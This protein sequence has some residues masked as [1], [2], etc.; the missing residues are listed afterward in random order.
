MHWTQDPIERDE[1]LAAADDCA[2]GPRYARE[3]S[4]SINLL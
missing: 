2:E 1:T 4:V 3:C